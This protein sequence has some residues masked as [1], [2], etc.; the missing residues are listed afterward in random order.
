MKRMIIS[1]TNSTQDSNGIFGFTLDDTKKIVLQV[2]TPMVIPNLKNI[3]QISAGADYALAL[4]KNGNVYGWGSG[5]QGQLGRR[6]V[7]RHRHEFLIPSIMAL[8]KKRIIRVFAGS[9]H[10]FAIDKD[11][12]TWAWGLNNYAQTAINDHVGESNGMVTTPTKITFFKNVPM[13]MLAGGSHH[14]IGIAED[15][16]LYVWGRMDSHQMGI[17]LS[18]LPTND[19]DKVVLDER[20]SPRILL[21]PT[22]IPNLL[23]S[24][25]AAG[26]DHNVAIS[27]D[28]KAFSW[29]FNTT[30][31]CGQGDIDS[32]PEATQIVN[33]ATTGKTMV[34][35]GAGGQYSIFA[36]SLDDAPTT[37]N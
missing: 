8:P 20:E 34:W 14:S 27:S 5:Q 28:G 25:A 35:V 33:K 22:P 26:S 23:F 16:K 17:A 4:D 30:Y 13:K 29:G 37:E 31:Q 36:A 10:A 19:P 6:L 3:V 1:G 24:F 21:E 11:K 7:D 9:N 12:H 32:V 15:G 2:N 18:S